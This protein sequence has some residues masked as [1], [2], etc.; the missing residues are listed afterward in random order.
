MLP[1]LQK[2]LRGPGPPAPPP[3]PL[4]L[5]ICI[6]NFND[7]IHVCDDGQG[8]LI[9]LWSN[10]DQHNHCISCKFQKNLTDNFM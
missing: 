8:K 5:R 10:F 6:Y 2:L 1:P 7:F 4:F 9:P 3:S